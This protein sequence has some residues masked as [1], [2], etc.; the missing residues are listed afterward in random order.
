[1]YEGSYDDSNDDSNEEEEDE[2]SS[3]GF[4]PD[5]LGESPAA[6]AAHDPAG[7]PVAGSGISGIGGGGAGSLV[8]G[9]WDTPGMGTTAGAGTYDE[10][11]W[12]GKPGNTD[13]C[14][15][16]GGNSSGCDEAAEEG[17]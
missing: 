5:C 1:M 3:H 16:S 15:L 14:S 6:N 11:P 4:G 10:D 9:S 17:L 7:P 13:G 2:G 12:D 8:N